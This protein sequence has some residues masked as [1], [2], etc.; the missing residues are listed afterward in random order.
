MLAFISRN[1]TPDDRHDERPKHVEF[2]EIKVKIQLHLRYI[3][4]CQTNLR[5][6]P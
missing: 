6:L 5:L 2:L 1:S 4:T 3:Y